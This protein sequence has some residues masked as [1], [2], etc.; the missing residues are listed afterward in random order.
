MRAALLARTAAALT[1]VGRAVF[2]AG[3]ASGSSALSSGGAA[4]VRSAGPQG[5][6]P[7][8]G[9]APRPA[10]CGGGWAADPLLPLPSL[11]GAPQLADRVQA[12]EQENAELMAMCDQLMALQ[13]AGR[14]GA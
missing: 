1:P 14:G 8:G 5:R 6:V 9:G 11:H 4:A 7:H 10:G 13:E 2:V 12:K 3:G